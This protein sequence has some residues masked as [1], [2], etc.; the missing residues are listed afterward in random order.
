MTAVPVDDPCTAPLADPTLAIAG[1]LLLHVPPVAA[2]VKVIVVPTQILD[3]PVIAAGN[4]LTVIT[5]LAEQP[6]GIE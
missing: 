3:T 1:L 4:A 2:V 6:D 5:L